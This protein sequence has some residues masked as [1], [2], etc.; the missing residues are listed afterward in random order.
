MKNK[1]KLFG[2]NIIL[3]ILYCNL[4]NVVFII[5]NFSKNYR[6][7]LYA[8]AISSST[9]IIFNNF[10]KIYPL[11]PVNIN[12]FNFLKGQIG[13]LSIFYFLSFGM[14]LLK[15]NSKLYFLHNYLSIMFFLNS[16]AICNQSTLKVPKFLQ[17]NSF[18]LYFILYGLIIYFSNIPLLYLTLGLLFLNVILLLISNKL[19]LS[20]RDSDLEKSPGKYIIVDDNFIYLRSFLGIILFILAF[21]LILK[22]DNIIL[23]PIAI[24]SIL[25][26]MQIYAYSGYKILLP[27]DQKK[28]V[29]KK[30]FLINFFGPLIFLLAL[31]IKSESLQHIS[32]YLI[33]IEIF[34][35]F[36]FLLLNLNLKVN[37]VTIISYFV[38]FIFFP[39]GRDFI[40]KPDFIISLFVL[41]LVFSLWLF[42]RNFEDLDYSRE[43][44]LK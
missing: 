43:F 34:S 17:G 13:F 2:K 29:L 33:V 23:A 44:L 19:Y 12:L 1:F 21:T 16:F 9:M 41:S 3:I 26:S 20:N 31:G 30:F 25:L 27:F 6:V 11:L 37:L 4:M 8:I 36:T 14:L 24:S 22:K 40:F 5:N 28:I 42:Y 32:F 35:N 7:L 39:L 38:A 18:L 15:E 10:H